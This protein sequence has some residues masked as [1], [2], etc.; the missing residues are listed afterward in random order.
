MNTNPNPNFL[1]EYNR[2]MLKDTFTAKQ[3]FNRVIKDKGCI[4]AI[5]YALNSM[6]KEDK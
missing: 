5:H 2:N 4:D 3:I 1:P 6:I